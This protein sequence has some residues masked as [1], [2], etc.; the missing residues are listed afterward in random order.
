L[1]LNVTEYPNINTNVETARKSGVEGAKQLKPSFYN[2]LL[3]HF[4]DTKNSIA[5]ELKAYS[6]E[7]RVMLN[8][9]LEQMRTEG[10][11]R[12]Q[13]L[14]F[15]LLLN[16]EDEGS[17]DVFGKCLDIAR[18][19]MRG[20]KVSVEEMRLLAQHFPQLLFQ[21]LLLRQEKPEFD[22]DKEPE[23]GTDDIMAEED[24]SILL[25]R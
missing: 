19:I 2:T 15:E 21:A 8:E 22:K 6:R 7:K 1:N 17:Y 20:E 5:N 23:T 3:S 11:K 25:N 12:R 16:D 13:E 14:L 10:E 18:R 9:L 4:P 24:Y